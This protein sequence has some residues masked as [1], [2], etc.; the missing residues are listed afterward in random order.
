MP[1]PPRPAPS[2]PPS[3]PNC[4]T[5]WG[6]AIWP[7][8]SGAAKEERAAKAALPSF[9]Q[10]RE[11]DGRHYFKVMDAAGRLLAQS[12]GFESPQEA[13]RAVAQLRQ[14]RLAGLE[15][16]LQLADGTVRADLEAAL[17]ALTQG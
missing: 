17:A 7:A 15:E 6:C 1:A 16:S 11:A 2:P 3:W 8:Q 14:G 12:T 10:Y 13:G 4:A 9:K 5:P